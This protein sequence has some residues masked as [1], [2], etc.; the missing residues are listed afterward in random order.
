LQA[1]IPSLFQTL[2][3]RAAPLPFAALPYLQADRVERFLVVHGQILLN[4][5]RNF[6]KQ[7]VARS[8][9]VGALKGKMA[10]R[11]HHKLY[12]SKTKAVA[13][14]TGVNRNPM[15]VGSPVKVQPYHKGTA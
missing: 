3:K 2:S 11:R 15:K 1:Q 9:F 13:R 8:A 7:A 5:I 4:Q 10:T 6:P 14:S 12:I